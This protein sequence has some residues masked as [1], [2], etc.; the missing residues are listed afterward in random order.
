MKYAE[1]SHIT[2]KHKQALDSLSKA[3]TL[4]P[5][6]NAYRVRASV[7]ISLEENDKALADVGKVVELNPDVIGTLNWISE[8]VAKCRTRHFATVS[9]NWPTRRSD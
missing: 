2:K 1:R 3:I 9:S 8:L 7:Y 4:D 5:H 6:P